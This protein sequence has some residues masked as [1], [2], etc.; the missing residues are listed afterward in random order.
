MEVSTA[1]PLRAACT[2]TASTLVVR[3]KLCQSRGTLLG[4]SRQGSGVLHLERRSQHK[5][6]VVPPQKWAQHHAG[7]C[8]RGCRAAG[9]AR[10]GG[11]PAG[12]WPRALVPD[13]ILSP[14]SSQGRLGAGRGA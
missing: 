10:L 9:W 12:F 8:G 5:G 2:G 4:E 1:A 13:R 14:V 6:C 3:W 7:G 11:G